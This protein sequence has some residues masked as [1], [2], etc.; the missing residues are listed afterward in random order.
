MKKIISAVLL[1]SFLALGAV[2]ASASTTSANGIQTPPPKTARKA[3]RRRHRRMR[4]R[5]H[6]AMHRR[7]HK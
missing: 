4:R 3:N 5:H 7:H 1:A 6:R 2:F